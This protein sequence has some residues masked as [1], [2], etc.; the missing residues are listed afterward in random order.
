M[1]RQDRWL[2]VGAYTLGAL[3]L[4]LL[5]TFLVLAPAASPSLTE[6]L[7]PND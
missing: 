1:S 7:G 6:A 4:G 2:R 5:A 3:C